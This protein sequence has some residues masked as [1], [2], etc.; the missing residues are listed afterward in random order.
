[1]SMLPLAYPFLTIVLVAQV[2]FGLILVGSR[3][4]MEGD[5]TPIALI[6]LA[7]IGLTVSE[8]LAYVAEYGHEHEPA[9][10]APRRRRSMDLG[11][12]P[13]ALG[14]RTGTDATNQSVRH[15]LP[16]Q[17]E[18]DAAV[19]DMG[20]PAKKS[21]AY[22]TETR[23]PT[24]YADYAAEPPG[25]VTT[26]TVYS[27]A[28]VVLDDASTARQQ[29]TI[30]SVNSTYR[31]YVGEKPMLSPT[32]TQGRRA[33][34][35]SVTSSGQTRRISASHVFDGPHPPMPPTSPT[36]SAVSAGRRQS[37]TRPSLN[38]DSNV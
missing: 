22:T 29:R 31:D 9:A 4:A 16:T 5:Q 15:A 6:A 20:M 2:V 36:Y 10:K 13:S 27:V 11:A 3:E 34:R 12:N 1:M 37:S 28:D 7:I 23:P 26:N 19:V 25:A 17:A 18:L 8:V 30:A 33:S 21:P 38:V 32:G 14:S 35:T 24:R